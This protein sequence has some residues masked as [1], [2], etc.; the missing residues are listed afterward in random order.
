MLHRNRA[1]PLMNW[2]WSKRCDM[3]P[4]RREKLEEFVRGHVV[5]ATSDVLTYTTISSI[6]VRKMCVYMC[7]FVRGEL[8]DAPVMRVG[9]RRMESV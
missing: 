7:V 8:S 6:Q 4:Q 1:I 9:L 2:V 3:V 5:L